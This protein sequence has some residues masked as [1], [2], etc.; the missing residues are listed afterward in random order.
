MIEP[1]ARHMKEMRRA[2]SRSPSCARGGLRVRV[3]V[4]VVT[5]KVKV[6]VARFRVRV[7]VVRGRGRGRGRSGLARAAP[8][9]S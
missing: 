7:R 6:R 4:R 1:E 9:A 8:P 5:V 3:R 2:L